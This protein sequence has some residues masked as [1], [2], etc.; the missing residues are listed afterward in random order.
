MLRFAFYVG[1]AD[2]IYKLMFLPYLLGA[3]LIYCG[4]QQVA[5]GGR[6]EEEA[7]DVTQTT[8]VRSL[9]WCLGD[10][11]GEFYDEEGEAMFLYSGKTACMTLL[12]VA[13]V[14]LLSTDLLFGCDATLVKL[15]L[16]P[17]PYVSVSSSVV[18]LFTLRALFS[19]MRDVLSHLSLARYCTGIILFFVGTEMLA[20]GFTEV[21]A[22]M[23]LI[24]VINV[25]MLMAAFSAVRDSTCPKRVQ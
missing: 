8:V 9:R 5:V 2:T 16:I 25:I 17:T 24:V 6:C 12:G 23:S 7:A 18:A 15:E 20:A 19:V 10:R 11:L 3:W 22:L 1:L 21:S 13:V 4:T 14:C